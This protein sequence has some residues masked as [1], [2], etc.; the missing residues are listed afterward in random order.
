MKKNSHFFYCTF[1]VTLKMG[2]GARFTPAEPIHNYKELVEVGKDE[3]APEAFDRWVDA[4]REDLKA[5]WDS[6]KNPDPVLTYAYAL[7]P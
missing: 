3:T 1:H 2:P 7:A 6:N 4:K 5:K